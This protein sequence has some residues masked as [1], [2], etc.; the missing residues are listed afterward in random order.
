[1]P[2]QP[3]GDID[4]ASGQNSVD[5]LTGRNLRKILEREQSTKSGHSHGERLAAHIAAFCGSMPFIWIHVAFFFAWIVLN[6]RFGIVPAMDPFPF[7]F[8]SFVVSLEAIFLSAFILIS[9]NQEKRLTERR[10]HLDLQI[11]LLTEQ[12]NTHMMKMLR[13]I[14]AKV[15]ADLHEHPDMAALEQAT[16]PERLLEQIDQATQ[17]VKKPQTL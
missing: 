13:A 9:Q 16:Q 10:S 1:M 15:G 3:A 7:F 2:S 14:A 17:R 11:N 5:E 4:N 6:T 8:L 12:E